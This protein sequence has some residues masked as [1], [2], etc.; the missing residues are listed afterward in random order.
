MLTADLLTSM[1]W[2]SLAVKALQNAEQA[3]P[4]IARTPRAKFLAGVVAFQSG[5][6]Q[7]F[8]TV[9]TPAFRLEDLKEWNVKQP[10][11][12]GGAATLGENIADKMA[13]YPGLKVF[14]YSL[15]GDVEFAKGNP[16]GARAAYKAAEAIRPSPSVSGR[17]WT[18]EQNYVVPRPQA[19]KIRPPEGTLLKTP[20]APT[21]TPIAGCWDTTTLGN[22]STFCVRDGGAIVRNVVFANT[23]AK[24]APA[25]CEAG[26]SIEDQGSQASIR[27]DKGQCDNGK[28]LTE[29]AL[30]CGKSGRILQCRRTKDNLPIMYEKKE[31]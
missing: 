6:A 30:T 15:R 29:D 18:L 13:L 22:T 2:P 31:Q 26:G 19:D 28:A 10:L 17:L 12:T 1:N 5:D 11:A 14:G 25:H 20:S 9:E 27:F 24:S 4:A 3:S 16:D 21:S 23:A 7:V 8:K